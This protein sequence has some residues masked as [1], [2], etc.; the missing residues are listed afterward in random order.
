VH[1]RRSAPAQL[2]AGVADTGAGF[3]GSGGSG[4]GL[5]NTRARLRAL[6]GERGALAL[7]VNQPRGVRA[8]IRVPL[9]RLPAGA[10]A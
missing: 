4:L 3:S 9:V 2:E 1:A 5:A 8:T 10:G 6:Y 7:A